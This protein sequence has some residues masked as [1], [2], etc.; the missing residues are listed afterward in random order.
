[1]LYGKKLIYSHNSPFRKIFSWCPSIRQWDWGTERLSDWPRWHPGSQ[2]VFRVQALRQLHC[3]STF[4]IVLRLL[5][6]TYAFLALLLQAP[7]HSSSSLRTQF[8][9]LGNPFL[10]LQEG[11]IHLSSVLPGQPVPTPLVSLR[12][13]C[14]VWAHFSLLDTQ[15][16]GQIDSYSVCN[17]SLKH[18]R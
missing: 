15:H 7:E 13:N 2:S 4:Q 14:K 1:M 18:K 8:S 3:A 5:A 16:S 9:H 12:C 17:P 10:S 6:F 11:I